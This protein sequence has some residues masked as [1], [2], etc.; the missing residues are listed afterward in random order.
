LK[1]KEREALFARIATSKEAVDRAREELEGAL[2]SMRRMPRAEKVTVGKVVEGA[3]AS[4][5]SARANLVALEALLAE[6]D[7]KKG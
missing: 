6:Q 4:V 3:F 5:Q 7:P 1:A 2:R